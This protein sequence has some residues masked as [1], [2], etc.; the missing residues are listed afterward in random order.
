MIVTE[1]INNNS[2]LLKNFINRPQPSQIRYYASRGIEV[3][4]NHKLTIIG[5]FDDDPIAYGHI[6]HDN[7]VNW[8]GMCILDAYQGLGYGKKKIFL[9]NGL[10]KDK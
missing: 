1:I 4:K 3:I 6:D 2:N 7:G 8:I 9:F 10:C 5:T